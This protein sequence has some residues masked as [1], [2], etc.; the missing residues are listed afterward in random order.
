M[1][2]VPADLWQTLNDR[3]D[4]CTGLKELVRYD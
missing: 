3:Y 1:H 2:T 4:I